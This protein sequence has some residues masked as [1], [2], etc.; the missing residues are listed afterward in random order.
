MA[1][2]PLLEEIREMVEALDVAADD[3]Y[4]TVKVVPLE[5]TNTE[6]VQKALNMLIRQ[7]R[8]RNR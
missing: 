4:H 2:R 5:K 7:R 3:A 6:A 8:V 1:S